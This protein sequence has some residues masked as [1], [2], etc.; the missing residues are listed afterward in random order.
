MSL[1][2]PDEYIH[3]TDTGQMEGADIELDL[4]LQSEGD[5]SPTAEIDKVQTSIAQISPIPGLEGVVDLIEHA[6]RSLL[7]LKQSKARCE[8]IL[9]GCIQIWA[10]VKEADRTKSETY[11]EDL[12]AY[13]V[14]NLHKGRDLEHWTDQNKSKVWWI[15]NR[16]MVDKRMESHSLSVQKMLELLITHRILQS[17]IQLDAVGGKLDSI[18][19]KLVNMDD[20]LIRF[21][22]N[23]IVSTDAEQADA[24]LSACSSN[25]IDKQLSPADESEVRKAMVWL[26]DWTFFC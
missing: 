22:K 19:E 10:L 3:C 1:S 15:V 13:T 4:C 5:T 18:D 17:G 7:S 14:E 20:L 25:Q 6:D 9:Q 24:D 2:P 8:T 21:T 26:V 11:L 23:F 16:R 12:R